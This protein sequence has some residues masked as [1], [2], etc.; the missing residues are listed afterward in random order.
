MS[1]YVYGSGLSYRDYLQAR[2][3]ERS[4][5]AII[6]SQTRAL[7]ASAEQLHRDNL[8]ISE[9]ISAG[10]AVGFETLSGQ[11][12]GIS[13]DIRD[14][15][16]TVQWGF[17][18]L[19]LAIGTVNDSL[20]EL[21]RYSKSPAQTWA[22]EQF[23]IAR[24]AFR[25][26]LYDDALQHLDRAINGFA[27]QTGYRLEHRF[28]MLL[29][30]IHIGSR[31]N[32]SPSI[33]SMEK[34]EQAFVD[35]AKYARRDHLE[36]AGR[37]LLGASWAAYCQGNMDAAR[38][39]SEAAVTSYPKLGDAHFQLAKVLMHTDAPD[40]ALAPLRCAIQL[41]RKYAVTAAADGDFQAHQ[42]KVDGLLAALRE[43]AKQVAHATLTEVD[44]AIASAVALSVESY[45]FPK[46]ATVDE[47]RQRL[48]QARR[49]A[50]AS[51]YFGYLDAAQ[52][53]RHARGLLQETVGAFVKGAQADCRKGIVEIEQQI[54]RREQ[55]DTT[56]PAWNMAAGAMI[57]GAILS[58]LFG[59][60]GCKAPTGGFGTWLSTMF[61]GLIISAASSVAVFQGL[62]ISAERE[63]S[64]AIASFRQSE[65]RFRDTSS[66][67]GQLL[68]TSSA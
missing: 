3:F 24:D 60:Q 62:K 36:E 58:F 17:S 29:G 4:I 10:L 57:L 68:D 49:S 40:K 63:R 56:T 55:T 25:Q 54:R 26:E 9:G 16:A 14:L 53:C 51:T 32:T 65:Q 1:N 15:N 6:N 64:S 5:E 61:W 21:I 34:A 2:S 30:T 48:E 50:S 8:A 39:Y 42:T 22:Y 31:D 35:A 37:A 47:P 46:Y 66:A 19:V 67:L 45:A 20:Q 13:D 38:Q 43:E 12:S 59:V 52:H 11:L 23:E 44:Q 41:D 7:I 18:N 27:S 28:H 33:V